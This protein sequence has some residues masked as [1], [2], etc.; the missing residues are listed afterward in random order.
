M[1]RQRA[2]GSFAPAT[3]VSELN[4]SLHDNMPNIR[5]DGLEMVFNSNRTGG[6][7]AQDVY[8]ASRESTADPWSAPVNLGPNVNTGGSETRASLSWDGTR[9]HF[10]RDGDIQVS[11]RSR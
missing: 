5:K 11:T 9:L 7:G 4:S 6:I 2:D 10:G 3:P 8:T 1:S